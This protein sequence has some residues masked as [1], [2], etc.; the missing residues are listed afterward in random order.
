MLL[1]EKNAIVY[2]AGGAIG[3]AVART[4][5]REGARVHLTGRH[6]ANVELVARDIN[7]SGGTAH[8]AVVDA[9]DEHAVE[10]HAARVAEEAGS[11][12]VSINLITRNDV[13]GTPLVDLSVSDYVSCV[14]RGL[15]TNFVTARAA[16][17]RM[18]AQGSGVILA[19]NSGSSHTSPMMGGTCP[20]DAAIDTLIRSLAQELGPSGV[21]AAGLWAAGVPETLTPQKLGAVNPAMATPEALRGV[22]DTLDGLRM[23][24]ASP[25]LKEIADL[26]A[27]LASDHAGAVTGTW[28]NATA[29]FP[30]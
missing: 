30:S 11:L 29:M 27:F 8:A 1:Q 7:E 9:L 18:A 28:V 13:Q 20:A 17:K 21:R 15:T 26:A 23:L 22:L 2:G 4:F 14:T 12:D 24:P 5:A 16:G 10:E 3:A 19:L 25:R 6:A